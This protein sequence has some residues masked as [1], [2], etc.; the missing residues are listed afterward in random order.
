MHQLRFQLRCVYIQQEIRKIVISLQEKP[1]KKS[2]INS[3]NNKNKKEEASKVDQPTWGEVYKLLREVRTRDVTDQAPPKTY[4]MYRTVKYTCTDCPVC[5]ITC[6]GC[7]KC[8][9]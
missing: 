6:T 5:P 8:M 7:L 4:E 3:E 9:N 2:K 1:K